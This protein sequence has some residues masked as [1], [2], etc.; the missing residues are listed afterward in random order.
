MVRYALA[1]AVGAI[2]VANQFA[3]A[4]GAGSGAATGTGQSDY[5]GRDDSIDSPGE[6][7]YHGAR[8]ANAHDELTAGAALVKGQQFALAIPHLEAALAKDPNNIQTLT[9]LGFVHRM[10]GATV[11]GNTQ[12]EEFTKALGYYRQGLALAPDNKLLHEYLGKLYLLMHDEHGA[13]TEL[14]TLTHLCPDGC[15]ES[16]ALTVAIAGNLH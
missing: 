13:A 6:A 14:D 11:T 5:T 15:T 7:R 1:L 9:Y 12:T 16:Q 10:I 8:D 4:Q 3:F 2:I